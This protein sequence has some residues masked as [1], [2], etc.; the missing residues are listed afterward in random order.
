AAHQTHPDLEREGVDLERPVE[1]RQEDA[2]GGHLVQPLDLLT[3]PQALLQVRR[4]EGCKLGRERIRQ[5]AHRQQHHLLRKQRAGQLG[6]RNDSVADVVREES[7]ARGRRK[8][9]RHLHGRGRE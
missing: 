7:R 8:A 2:V 4:R 3:T 9:I 1:A 6:R 5:V